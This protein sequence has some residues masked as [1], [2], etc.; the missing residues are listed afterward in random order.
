[1][2][3]HHQLPVD[4]PL[5]HFNHDLLLQVLI[6]PYFSHLVIMHEGGGGGGSGGVET[7]EPSGS[8][9]LH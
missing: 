9:E 1:M 5:E 4:A 3:F 6:F 8:L 2:Y 7:E